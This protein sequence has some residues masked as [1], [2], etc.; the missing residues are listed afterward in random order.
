MRP[1]EVITDEELILY[2]YEESDRSTEIEQALGS[3]AELELRY[4]ELRLVLDSVPIDQVPARSDLYGHEVWK[5]VYPQLE[6]RS[7]WSQLPK[8]AGWAIA[9]TLLIVAGFWAGRESAPPAEP[10]T[11]FSAQARNRIL[12]VSIADHLERSQ[13]LLLELVNSEESNLSTEGLDAARQLKAESRLYRQAAQRSG[14]ADAAFVL[15]ELERFLTELAHLEPQSGDDL[16]ALLVRLEEKNL[17]FKVHV[18][19]SEL[20]ERTRSEERG[21]TI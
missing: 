11:A 13:F 2:Y 15:D 9:A 6:A 18:L 19:G 7:R 17:L 8:V 16:N 12:L 20:E 5:R 14:E 10:A 3:S 4:T 21:A 1:P